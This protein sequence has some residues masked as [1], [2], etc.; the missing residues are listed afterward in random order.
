MFIILGQATVNQVQTHFSWRTGFT[1]SVRNQI[2][3]F[4]TIQP[5]SNLTGTFR[6]AAYLQAISEP[7]EYGKC[8]SSLMQPESLL[9]LIV[10]MGLILLAITTSIV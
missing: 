5:L 4:V 8:R 10:R 9:I 7:S 3:I 6:G 2:V 1:M